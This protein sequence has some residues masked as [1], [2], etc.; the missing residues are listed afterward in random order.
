MIEAVSKAAADIG[1][2][3]RRLKVF[4]AAVLG[5][6]AFYLFRFVGPYLS[7]DPA[8]YEHFWPWRYALWAHL[9][10]GLIAVLT[11]PVQLWLGM[12]QRHVPLHRA[13]GKVYLG[14]ATLGLSG[15]YY[16]VAQEIRTDWVFASGLLG[17]AMAW[18]LTTGM[19][20]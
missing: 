18:T 11:G 12:T 3:R 8:Y 10:G 6:A 4:L 5:V 13:L 19:A 15:A 2:S 7:F 16:L 20:Y 1:G 9:T 17:L 14:A